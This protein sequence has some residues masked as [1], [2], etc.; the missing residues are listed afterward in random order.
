VVRDVSNRSVFIHR[1]LIDIYV[2][3]F[4]P[5]QGT[6]CSR[7]SPPLAWNGTILC[8]E[9]SKLLLIA[10]VTLLGWHWPD[11]QPHLATGELEREADSAPAPRVLLSVMDR[12]LVEAASKGVP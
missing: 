4:G 3:P 10:T 9:N 1:P 12:A 6:A 7:S 5:D 2:S 8:V 11:A